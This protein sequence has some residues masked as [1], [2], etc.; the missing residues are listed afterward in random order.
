M[1]CLRAEERILPPRCHDLGG[2][3]VGRK[4]PRG[5]IR[6]SVGAEWQDFCHNDGQV[7]VGGLEQP[8]ASVR[9]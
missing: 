5:R 4:V 9:L 7:M 6:S 8:S 3:G 1:Q 2:L